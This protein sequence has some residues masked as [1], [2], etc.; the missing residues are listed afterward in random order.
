MCLSVCLSVLNSETGSTIQTVL[1]GSR[2]HFLNE[3][4]GDV[5]NHCEF[6]NTVIHLQ[7]KTHLIQKNLSKYDFSPSLTFQSNA[8]HTG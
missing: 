7:K 4:G 8:V 2:H 3:V 1:I 6:W 5:A